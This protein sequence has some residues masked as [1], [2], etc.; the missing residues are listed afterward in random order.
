[1]ATRAAFNLRAE[2]PSK[3]IGPAIIMAYS[4]FGKVSFIEIITNCTLK[5]FDEQKFI[6]DVKNADFS[7]ETDDPKRKEWKVTMLLLLQ[8]YEK[9][10]LHNK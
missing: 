5:R 3:Y 1:M 9:S 7:L 10:H 4:K 2:S 8:R 6:A